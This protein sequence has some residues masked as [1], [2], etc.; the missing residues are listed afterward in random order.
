MC[1]CVWYV[2][3]VCVCG[4]CVWYVCGMCVWYVCGMCVVYKVSFMCLHRTHH[5][6]ATHN[7]QQSIVNMILN[8][9]SSKHIS[10]C[11]HHWDIF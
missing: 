10:Q 5:R 6:S 2:C 9:L 3:V 4:M 7:L 1:V 8:Q 11:F